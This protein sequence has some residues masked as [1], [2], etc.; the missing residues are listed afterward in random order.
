MYITHTIP[1]VFDNRS[2]VLLLGSMPSPLSRQNGFYYG[3]PQNRFWQVLAAVLNVPLPGTNEAKIALLLSSRIALWD[4][5]AGC[6]IAGA[7]DASIR[8]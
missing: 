1:P 2:R 4:V 7:S 6:D 8:N 5:L 3:N